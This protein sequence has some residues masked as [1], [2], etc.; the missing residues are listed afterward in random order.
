MTRVIYLDGPGSTPLE[1]EVITAMTEVLHQVHAN[2]GSAHA[3][4][5]AAH[6]LVEQAR[7]QVAAIVASGPASVI[8]TSGAT[9]SNALALR[10]L[11][12][13]SRRQTIVSCVT[14]HPA[15]LRPLEALQREGR[16][17]RLVGVDQ[18]GRIDLDAL[19]A[20]IDDSTLLV[21]VMAANNETGVL[22]DLASIVVLAH[23][24]GAYV[25]TDASQLLAW[26]ALPPDHGL[27]LITVS[28]HKMHGP[29]G[30]GALIASRSAR[31]ALR[32]LQVGGGQERG[33]RS[34]T[35][36]VAGVVGLGMA[37]VLAADRGPA[38]AERTRRLR[39]ALHLELGQALPMALLNG[40]PDHRLPGTLNLAVG[41]EGDEVD[42]AAVL[43][44]APTVAASAGSACSAGTQ[45]PSPVLLAMGLSRARAASS[46][47]FGLSRLS[48]ARDVDEAVP[49]LVH[50]VHTVRERS[51]QAREKVPA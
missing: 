35:T 29:Q 2:P 11:P 44:Q 45:E 3:P 10:G 27:D 12:P 1:A 49:A 31:R 4:G 18:Q 46:I 21:S 30:V 6:A 14:E 5:R 51:S 50:A 42:A 24:A 8:F 23:E 47:R 39:D 7:E 9:E 15:V 34:G 16:P 41:D 33:L 43:A 20:A 37:T 19:A 48:T 22:A 38:T 26:G 17:V 36:N 13:A 32:P 28:G 40:H 25:H